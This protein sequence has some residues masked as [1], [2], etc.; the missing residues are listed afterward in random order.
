VLTVSQ[1]EL[2]IL[3]FAFILIVP[4]LLL[5]IG[6]IIAWRRRRA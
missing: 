1:G 4:G 6:G 2:N 5:I 3:G